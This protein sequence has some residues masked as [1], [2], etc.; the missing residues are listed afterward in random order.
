MKLKFNILAAALV[1]SVVV[2]SAA[3]HVP[4]RD[5]SN[6]SRA[7]LPV[8][9]SKDFVRI[10]RSGTTSAPAQFVLTA[11]HLGGRQDAKNRAA[12][13]EV[14][15]ATREQDAADRALVIARANAVRMAST[16]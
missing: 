11:D 1:S 3:A 5:G 13:L 10:L 7:P 2:L 12:A 6:S 4:V 15:R 8:N 9:Q 16:Q 14:A